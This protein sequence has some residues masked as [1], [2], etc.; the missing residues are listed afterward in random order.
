MGDNSE[1]WESMVVEEDDSI[2]VL[3]DSDIKAGV[4]ERRLLEDAR[5]GRGECELNG[6]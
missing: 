2:K 5:C 4:T 1:Q 6:G 3:L